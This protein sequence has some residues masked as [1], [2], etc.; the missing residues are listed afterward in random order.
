MEIKFQRSLTQEEQ[1]KVRLYVGFYRGISCFKEDD[2]VEITPKEGFAGNEF[3]ATLKTI[4]IPIK[5]V[6]VQY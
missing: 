4:R 3:L 5:N 2:L 6:N 1:E